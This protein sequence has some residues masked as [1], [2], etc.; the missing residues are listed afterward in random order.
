VSWLIPVRREPA[1]TAWHGPGRCV[2][3]LGRFG[4]VEQPG[5]DGC[6]SILREEA[7]NEATQT[8]HPVWCDPAEC[9]FGERG[10]HQSA[11][12]VLGLKPNDVKTM[13]RVTQYAGVDGYPASGA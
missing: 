13:V 10:F 5:K 2:E 4:A 8:T 7:V 9:T 11:P 1:L 3:L 12:M 6:P